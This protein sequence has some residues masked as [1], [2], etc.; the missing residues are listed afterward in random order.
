[1][2]CYFSATGNC[3]YAAGRIAAALGDKSVSI[4]EAGTDISLSEGEVFGIITPTYFW[5]L[6]L[7]TREFLSAVRLPDSKKHYIFLVA[8][9]GTT[10]GCCGE[11]ARKLLK[12]HGCVLD[13]S[14]SL[15]MPD[16]WTPFFDLSD[17]VKVA[18]QNQKADHEMAGIIS[19]IKM[20]EKGNH[21][22]LRIPYVFRFLTDPLLNI[23]CR[24]KNFYAED[25]CIGCGL[26][27]KKCP[28]QAIEIRNGKPVWVKKRCDLC[29]GCLHRCPEFA[30]QYGDGRTK[31]H[32]QYHHPNAERG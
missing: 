18:H 10:P 28:A 17:P 2:I 8:T 21:T 1:M 11:H 24:T 9:Y 29:L 14:F 19:R 15:K 26:C 6:P 12:K 4:A 3:Q 31:L 23:A 20:Q 13:A 5:E 25:T 32:G 30:I 27:A 16:S 7:P 22:K